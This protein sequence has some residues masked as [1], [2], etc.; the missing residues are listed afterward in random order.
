MRFTGPPAK[1]DHIAWR[2]PDGTFLSGRVTR[3][4]DNMVYIC[5][6]NDTLAAFVHPHH[7]AYIIEQ[8]RS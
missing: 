8:G 2:Y 6:I 3:I 4:T 5:K 1:H 7:V